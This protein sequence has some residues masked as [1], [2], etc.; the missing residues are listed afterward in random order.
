VSG[1]DDARTRARAA[2]IVSVAEE[3]PEALLVLT[4]PTASGKSALAMDVAEAIGGEI[5]SADSVQIVRSFDIGS[6]KPTQAERARVA[7]HLIDALD[8]LEYADAARYAE[9]A[10]LAIDDALARGR[11]PIVCGGTFLWIRA[12]VYGLVDAP[13]ADE[14][15]RKA[16]RDLTT[17]DGRTALHERLRVVDPASAARLHPN[18]L[19][20]VS[21]ALEV[22]QTTGQRLSDLQ[23]AHGFRA[24]TRPARLFALAHSPDVLIER[25]RARVR[26]M[27]ASGW[28]EETRA[29]M[30]RGYGTARAM[31]S[32]GY[33]EVA[34]HLRGE[35]AAPDLEASIV[36]STRIYARRQRTFL[37][38]APIEW[39]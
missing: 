39:L 22:F 12:L 32:V 11:R 6:G 21:R 33:R 25:I 17:R 29:L 19:V 35:I 15:L 26:G 28:V 3:E 18:D 31:S 34:A 24:Q 4:G 1:A 38:Q 37:K 7:H 13:P 23:A 27:L 16:H 9:L 5:V 10:G 2:A 8:P 14:A 20:R 30:D 36:R